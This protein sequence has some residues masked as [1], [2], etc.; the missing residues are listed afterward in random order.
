MSRL[1]EKERDVEA[2]NKMNLGSWDKV[3]WCQCVRKSQINT[4][5]NADVIF[6][7]ALAAATLCVPIQYNEM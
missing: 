2:S 1:G 5:D 6:F 3:A 4:A 7:G